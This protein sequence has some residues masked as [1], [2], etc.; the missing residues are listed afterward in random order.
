MIRYFWYSFMV[1][2]I[3]WIWVNLMDHTFSM[4]FLQ[5]LASIWHVS[6]CHPFQGQGLLKLNDFEA[7]N[8]RCWIPVNV[9]LSDTC[10]EKENRINEISIN[11]TDNFQFSPIF[12]E[13][14]HYLFNSLPSPKVRLYTWSQDDISKSLKSKETM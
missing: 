4:K 9:A 14:K 7:G 6:L 12:A 10:A 1:N 11:R 5:N 8:D 2:K 3:E 13:K